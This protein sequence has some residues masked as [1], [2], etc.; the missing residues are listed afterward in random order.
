[1]IGAPSKDS[2]QPGH[3]PSLIRD[4]VVAQDPTFLHADSKHSDQTGR[5]G[6]FVGFVS[7]Q[8]KFIL[9]KKIYYVDSIKSECT[10]VLQNVFETAIQHMNIQ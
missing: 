9:K 2:D 5:T 7:L 8:L 3:P 4:F 10:G 1:M 6:H